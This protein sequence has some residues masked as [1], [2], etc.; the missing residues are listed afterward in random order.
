M[1][2]RESSRDSELSEFPMVSVIVPTHNRAA[3][4]SLLLES[5]HEQRYPSERMEV[6]VVHN[7]SEDG[8][9]AVVQ[10]FAEAAP[11]PVRYYLKD[12]RGPMPSRQFGAESAAGEIIAFI[13]DDCVATPQWLAAGVRAFAP[14]TGLVQGA[15]I[16][17]PDQPR[18]FLEKTVEVRRASPYFETCNIFYSREAFMRAG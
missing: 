1:P 8:T 14:N 2:C 5:L 12:Y 17:R 16:P 4:L 13:D 3:T 6:I 9:D 11:F 18:R 15:T 7:R 10:Q